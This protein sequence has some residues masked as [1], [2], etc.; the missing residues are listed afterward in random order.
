MGIDYLRRLILTG[1]HKNELVTVDD[2]GDYFT[3]T[4]GKEGILRGYL[5]TPLSDLRTRD[6]RTERRINKALQREWEKYG[7][8][9]VTLLPP[10]RPPTLD[11]A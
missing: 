11:A 8:F 9:R 3:P 1:A 10:T 2:S 7:R 5:S 6:L 4:R